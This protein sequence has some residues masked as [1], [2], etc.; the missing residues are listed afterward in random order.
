MHNVARVVRVHAI[1]NSDC[2]KIESA[3]GPAP[4]NDEVLLELKAIC[5]SRAEIMFCEGQ[6]LEAF[7]LPAR[8]GHEA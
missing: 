2:L 7:I 5:L 4:R 3:E 1:G 6:C 8:L